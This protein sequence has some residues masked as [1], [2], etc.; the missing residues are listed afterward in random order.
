[1]GSDLAY[2]QF[3]QD[4]RA[5]QVHFD[6]SPIKMN[7]RVLYRA[8]DFMPSPATSVPPSALE[9]STLERI[10]DFYKTLQVTCL[11]NFLII[12]VSLGGFCW[13]RFDADY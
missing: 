2:L 4:A 7:V 1:M 12:F 6:A 9:P 10:F 5:A 11:D 13:V 8:S 3:L